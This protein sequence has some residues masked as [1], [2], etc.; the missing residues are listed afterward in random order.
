MCIRMEDDYVNDDIAT[1]IKETAL[2]ELEYKD[3]ITPPLSRGVLALLLQGSTESPSPSP[4]SP[5]AAMWC[6]D[7][8]LL[9]PLFFW[10]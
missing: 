5:S 9:L 7:A 10:S 1:K 6:S 2:A 3:Y 4:T 8:R